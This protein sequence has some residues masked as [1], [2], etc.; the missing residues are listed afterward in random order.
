[1]TVISLLA[2]ILA[3]PTG[4]SGGNN[5]V[6]V[7]DTPSASDFTITGTSEEGA[8]KGEYTVN[9]DILPV[10]ITAKDGKSDGSIIIKYNGSTT[11]PVKGTAKFYIVTFDV[12]G[13]AKWNPVNGLSAGGIN[14]TSGEKL[15]PDYKD[16]TIVGLPQSIKQGDGPNPAISITA[17]YGTPTI[18]NHKVTNADA[19]TTTIAW[20]VTAANTAN[21]TPGL[22]NVTFDVGDTA[23][24]NGKMGIFAG[25]I[26]IVKKDDPVDP[27]EPIKVDEIKP[28]H[29]DII[30]TGTKGYREVFQLTS[31][32]DTFPVPFQNDALTVTIRNRP[33]VTDLKNPYPFET[34]PATIRYWL[35]A[36]G[37][38]GTMVGLPNAVDTYIV[39]ILI[40]D[41][42][43]LVAE[44][45]WSALELRPVLNVG[46]RTPTVDDF[47]YDLRV[48]SAAGDFLTNSI[49][50]LHVD[51]SPKTVYG[52]SLD[53]GITIIYNGTKADGTTIT[54]IVA[55]PTH[56]DDTHVG[57]SY[58]VGGPNTYIAPPQEAGTYTVT[59][60]VAASSG[61]T[62]GPTTADLTVPGGLVVRA[63]EPVLPTYTDY[64][65]FDRDVLNVTNRQLSFTAAQINAG[66]ATVALQQGTV[67][68]TV[69][70]WRVDGKKV[71]DSGLSY[72]FDKTALGW[73]YV[74]LVVKTLDVLDGTTVISP[75]KL[76]NETVE[77]RV[78]TMP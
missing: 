29:F 27:T 22:Y 72:T 60:R 62:W 53:G 33:G 43:D 46:V 3:C 76:Y 6:E 38:G 56:Q 19:P 34:R 15:N 63:L 47:E 9:D 5:N 42:V 36:V 61:D 48:Q 8:G 24:Y 1:V 10:V 49:K 25:T 23:T 51:I 11:P 12:G 31:A 55:G 2:L 28:E 69:H 71:A 75:G 21:A 54:E 26:N 39:Q 78:I 50:V 13:T 37:A 59:F 58:P 40:S 74:T 73:H 32:S 70:E 67:P 14:V 7:K 66:L 35:N 68:V 30:V 18:S 17:T 4:G 45:S 52:G 20:P 77:V 41:V 57:S 65:W 44:K 16:F 64:F